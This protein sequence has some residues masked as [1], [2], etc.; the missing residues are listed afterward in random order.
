MG[1]AV[2]Y[3]DA[4][5]EAQIVDVP[6][7]DAALEL[8]ERLRNDDDASDVRVFREVP[9]EVRTYYRVVALEEDAARSAGGAGAA[10]D[11]SPA[12]A[13]PAPAPAAVDPAV[14]DE[15]GAPEPAADTATAFDE[16][17]SAQDTVLEGQAGAD[18]RRA[19]DA[20]TSAA[21]P[22]PPSGATVV[23]PPPPRP[24][25]TSPAAENDEQPDAEPKR[26]LFNRG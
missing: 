1:H 17:A 18:A 10:V 5:G 26:A 6:S 14:P 25:E 4:A 16:P 24:D 21:P 12:V 2:H 23:S 15:A 7:L 3:Q 11:G 22:A 20:W 19:A 13:E 9:I 8:V